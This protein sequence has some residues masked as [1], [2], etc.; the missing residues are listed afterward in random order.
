M[1]KILL[2]TDIGGDIDDAIC[3]AYLLK[4]PQCELLGITTVCGESEKRASVADAIC[5]AAQK[6]VPIVAG[7]D[8]PLQPIP[9]YPTPD[10]ACALKSWPHNICEKGNAPAFM[11][12]NIKNNPHEVILIGIGNMTNI[13]SLFLTYPDAAELLKG[14]YVMNGYFGS[15]P[16]PDPYYNWNS[17]ADPLASKIVFETSIGIHRVIPL[18]VTDT[19]TVDARQAEALLNGDSAL[20]KAVLDFGSQWL[21]S[22]KKL[23]LH[24]PLAAVSVF[25]QE[26]CSFERGNVQ[27]ETVTKSRMGG[28]AFTP[29]S[30]GNTEIARTV[31]KDRFYQILT[32]VLN[33][34]KLCQNV[35]PLVYNRAKAAG[36]TG[37]DW[38]LGL[39]SLI[40]QLETKWS[41]YVGAPLSG[42]T[43]AYVACAV[44]TDGNDYVL[45]ADMPESMGHGD[46]SNG[47][48]ALQVAGGYGYAKLYA[49]DLQK[50]A[51]LLERLGTP[52]NQLNYTV[53]RQIAVICKTLTKSWQVSINNTSLPCG[54]DT[55]AWFR[56]FICDSWE[57]LHH[58]CPEETI[59]QAMAFLHSRES[60][61]NPDSYVLIHGDAHSGNILQ[62]LHNPDTFKLIDPDGIFYEK[63]YDLGVLMREWPEE[64]RLDSVSK[65]LKRCE[66]L[67][68]L[69]GA[70]K[71]AIWQWGFLQMVST[72]FV[73]LQTNQEKTGNEMLKIATQWSRH[74]SKHNAAE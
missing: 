35:P 31:Q 58:P 36:K 28:T 46:F 9:L 44:G 34:G 39:N 8:M 2:D 7:F 49:Y 38:L 22:S 59:K 37:Q 32:S 48:T 41:V 14:L 30:K 71:E 29:D 45:K 51:C 5:R 6:T 52:L 61:K 69:T 67:H 19:L 47:I 55:I 18:E 68:R 15:E 12:E 54:D 72:A 56:N 74:P 57:K 65:G 66:Y 24:D 20:M 25:H 63:A 27:V 16:L 13:A 62:N 26:I 73:F 50:R 4:E 53:E 33:D 3:L 42:G 21:E 17:W 23:T 70:D 60:Q 11:Y 1:E 10:G 64:Y 40:S 43:H